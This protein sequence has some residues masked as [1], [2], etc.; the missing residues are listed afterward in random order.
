MGGTRGLPPGVSV[1]RK[2]TKSRGSPN[3]LPLVFG[4]RENIGHVIHCE[5]AQFSAAFA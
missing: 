2:G 3:G 1:S 4:I 5:L